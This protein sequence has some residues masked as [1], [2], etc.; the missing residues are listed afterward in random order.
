MT[1]I[2]RAAAPAGRSLL[3]SSK[4]YALYSQS[5]NIIQIKQYSN[6]LQ[7]CVLKDSFVKNEAPSI[8][9][10]QT[11]PGQN[12]SRVLA[13]AGVDWVMVDCEHGNIDGKSP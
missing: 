1:L 5:K 7:G 3:S 12:V 11:L 6:M 10:W 8:G 4:R 2:A 13:R 9:V